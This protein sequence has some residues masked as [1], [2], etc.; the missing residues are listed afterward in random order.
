MIRKIVM[1]TV[2]S[3]KRSI[4]KSYKT[5]GAGPPRPVTDCASLTLELHSSIKVR[6]EII[7]I[8]GIYNLIQRVVFK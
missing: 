4:T 7:F 6:I 8:G 5:W 2:N 3:N 1:V